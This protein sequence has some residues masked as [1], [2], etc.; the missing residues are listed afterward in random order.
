MSEGDVLYDPNS[1]DI[2]NGRFD[3]GGGI[4]GRLVT[5]DLGNKATGEVMI[6]D[7]DTPTNNNIDPDLKGAFT[8]VDDE[9]EELSFGN[10]L[11]LQEKNASLPDDAVNGGAITF[12]FDNPV[13]LTALFILDGA[14]N[15]PNGATVFLDDI[16]FG[17][18][19]GGGDNEF[20][21]ISFDAG[22]VVNSFTVDFAGSGA[23]GRFGATVVP[24]P[25]ALPLM[26]TAFGALGFLAHRRKSR[27]AA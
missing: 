1:S 16:F 18:G 27:T 14:D 5:S 25:A 3:F 9:D 7:T 17:N 19:F 2:N 4:R 26:L 20:Q 21:R 8:N 10:A 13:A 22:T 6:F 15:S 12:L 23:I 24:V 11:I